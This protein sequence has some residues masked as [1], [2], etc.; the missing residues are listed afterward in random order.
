[1]NLSGAVHGLVVSV[2]PEEHSAAEEEVKASVSERQ[3][4]VNRTYPTQ[5]CCSKAQADTVSD[6]RDDMNPDN[7]PDRSMVT[8]DT[9]DPVRVVAFHDR[10]AL[11]QHRSAVSQ[12]VFD[13]NAYQTC[14]QDKLPLQVLRVRETRL[15]HRPRVREIGS[16]LL[17]LHCRQK[18]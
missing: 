1:M 2:V 7:Q 5:V 11:R 16:A 3:V 15:Q 4:V 17:V 18:G 6:A 10:L 9:F 8:A 14:D 12:F 13:N